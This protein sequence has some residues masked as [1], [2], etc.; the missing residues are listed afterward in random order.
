M[1]CRLVCRMHKLVAR[2]AHAAL[3]F[4]GSKWLFG[5]TPHAAKGRSRAQPVADRCLLR[6]CMNAGSS[7]TSS[8]DA[9]ASSRSCCAARDAG[10][11]ASTACCLPPKRSAGPAAEGPLWRSTRCS[12]RVA[13]T[14]GAG[15]KLPL[16]EH[17]PPRAERMAWSPAVITACDIAP[18][19][20]GGRAT[21]EALWEVES[22]NYC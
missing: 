12:P 6:T 8:A 9:V 20:G 1:Q 7:A 18:I 21:G 4:A 11:L 13:F 17:V 14:T 3:A 19:K 15:E 10:R 5:R 22:E 2:N 16:V